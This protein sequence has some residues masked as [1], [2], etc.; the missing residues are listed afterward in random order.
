[1]KRL[2]IIA[3]TI[4]TIFAASC[5][6]DSESISSTPIDSTNLHG[7]APASYEADNPDA[8]QHPK[9]EGQYDTGMRA[10]TVSSADTA[11]GRAQ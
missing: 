5:G 2:L 4:T 10:G 11:A 8:A 3:L 1:M 9:Y 6:D 7:T